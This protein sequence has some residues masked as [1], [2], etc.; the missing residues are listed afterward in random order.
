MSTTKKPRNHCYTLLAIAKKKLGWDDEFYRDVFLV[1]HGAKEKNG[2]VSASTLS[3]GQLHQALED[4]KAHGFK[5][6]QKKKPRSQTDFRTARIKKI[7]AIWLQLHK[8]HIVRDPSDTAMQRWCMSQT[9]K[10]RLDWATSNDLNN[11]IE[12][13]KLWA[14]REHVNLEH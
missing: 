12:A 10:A 2:R 8:E 14:T 1:K 13:L 3:I 6:M 5:P 7:T 9:K 11:C 4:M